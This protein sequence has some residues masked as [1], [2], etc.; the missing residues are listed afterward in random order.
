MPAERLEQAH[1]VAPDERLAAGDADFSHALFDEGGGQPVELFQRQQILLRQEMHVLRHAIDAAE[2]AAVGHRDAEI[3]D[4][5]A[6]R[7]DQ[8]GRLVA[9]L[10]PAVPVNPAFQAM[11]RVCSACA[12]SLSAQSNLARARSKG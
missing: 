8:R 12:V 10:A 2:V 5:P 4:R 9:R 1:D 7:I 3:G 11:N 6:E